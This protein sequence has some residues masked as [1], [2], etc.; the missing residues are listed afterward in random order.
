MD[1]I[2]PIGLRLVLYVAVILSLVWYAAW[3]IQILWSA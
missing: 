2:K 1:Y 3:T